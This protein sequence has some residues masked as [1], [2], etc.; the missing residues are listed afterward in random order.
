MGNSKGHTNGHSLTREV[1]IAGPARTPMGK[2]GG[3]LSTVPATSLGAA[4]VAGAIERS[5]VPAS[6]VDYTYMGNMLSA[7][8]GQTPARQAAIEA[9]IPDHVWQRLLLKA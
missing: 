5:G 2:F 9:G 1:V 8:L 7:G 4:A 6:D 3:A